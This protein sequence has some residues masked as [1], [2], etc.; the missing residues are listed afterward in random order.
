MDLLS[1]TDGSGT[2]AMRFASARVASMS[3][4]CGTTSFTMPMRKAS[5]ASK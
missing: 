3:W 4:S 5:C 2:S 1:R